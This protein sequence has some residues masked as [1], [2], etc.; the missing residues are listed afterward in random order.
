MITTDGEKIVIEGDMGDVM[1]ESVQIV[2]AITDIA[3]RII[4]EADDDN[5]KHL[6]TELSKWAADIIDAVMP[7]IGK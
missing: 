2:K 1:G 5:A 6:I 4:D 3:W 7:E